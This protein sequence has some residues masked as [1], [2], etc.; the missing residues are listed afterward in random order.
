M[1]ETDRWTKLL[2]ALELL[3]RMGTDP[4]PDIRPRR[5]IVATWH[6]RLCKG[7]TRFY[8]DK[9]LEIH[10]RGGFPDLVVLPNRAREEGVTALAIFM[11]RLATP[12]R[13]FDLAQAFGRDPSTIG[14]LCHW[15][16]QWVYD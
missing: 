6:P 15:V 12:S 10:L 13:Y 2:Q 11:A 8:P 16:Q 1:L 9:I 7:T 5:V 4:M 14:R 3:E